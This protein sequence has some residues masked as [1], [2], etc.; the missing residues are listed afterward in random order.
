MELSVS[1][2]PE[3]DG[4]GVASQVTYVSGSFEASDFLPGFGG[5]A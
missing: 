2:A 3:I 5:K 4:W 1:S